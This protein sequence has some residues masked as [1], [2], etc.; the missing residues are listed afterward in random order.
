MQNKIL[1]NEILRIFCSLCKLAANKVTNHR[2]EVNMT[3]EYDERIARKAFMYQRK[4]SVLTTV[5]VGLG[6]TF[7][8]A[9]LVQFHAFGINSVR[10]P[11]DNPNY[12]VP[13]P[14]AIIGKEGAKA[15]YV[16]NRAVAIRVLNGTKFRG[17]ARAVGEAL[18]ARGF[19]LTEVNNNKSSN[20]KRT[21]IYFG[22]NAINEAYTVSANFADAIMR[23]DD[24]QDKLVDIVLGS[25]FNNLRPKVDVPAAGAAIHEVQGCIRADLMKNIPKADQHKEVR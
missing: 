22:K 8:F 15:P 16:D 21:V 4:R 11:K 5:G 23:M 3:Q 25:T 6:V 24:R 19:N 14:C 12:G 1:R 2:S 20:I 18:N 13:A 9:L 17:F 10:A 7:I